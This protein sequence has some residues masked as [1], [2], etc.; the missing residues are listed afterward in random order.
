MGHPAGILSEMAWLRQLPGEFGSDEHYPHAVV[1]TISREPVEPFMRKWRFPLALCVVQ[2]ALTAL[3]TLWADRVD[4][5]LGDSNRIPPPFLKV[6]MLVIELRW[7][8]R[9]VNAPT[10]PFN[11]AGQKRSRILGLSLPEILYLFAVAALWFLVGYFRVRA[12]RGKFNPSQSTRPSTTVA[13]AILVWGVVLFLVTL[14][15]IRDA[16]PWTFTFGRTFNL[17][18]FLNAILYAVWSVVLVRFGFHALGLP[19]ARTGTDS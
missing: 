11:F 6:H 16:F 8:W 18:A 15:Q 9:G 2:T 3:L 10:F 1:S 7:V 13:V 14:L 5:L 4:W 19:H 17:V 12:K